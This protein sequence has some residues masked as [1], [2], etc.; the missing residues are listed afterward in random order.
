MDRPVT[1]QS[2]FS[3]IEV[4]VS[5][6]IFA[7]IGAISVALM[8]ASLTAQDVNRAA[9]DRM[10]ALDR[11][12][13]LLREDAGQI[14]LRPVRDADGY[15]ER[16]IFAADND[17]LVRTGGPVRNERILLS[18]TR[19]GRA[20]PGLLRERSSLLH[21]EY[22]VRGEALIR[23]VRAYP[24]A[25]DLTPDSE[26]VLLDAIRDVELD[27]LLGAA[28]SR[29]LLVRAG[30]EV[31]LPSA[32]RLRYDWDGMGEMEHVVLTPGGVR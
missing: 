3:L 9:L 14:V 23:R 1:A 24:D 19:R 8:S 10:A 2:G 7:V 32:I 11:V 20:N 25:T 22:L 5:V 31:G 16:E 28:W 27:V 13:T 18:F 17:G 15:P 29:R 4:L 6:F 26:I 21:V 12:R 30:G